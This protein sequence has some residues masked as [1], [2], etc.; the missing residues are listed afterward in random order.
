MSRITL[1]VTLGCIIISRISDR[2]GRRKP[3]LIIAAFTVIPT[4]F[5]LGTMSGNILLVAAFLNGFLLAALPIALEVNVKPK[6]IG[7]PWQVCQ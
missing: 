7:Q 3:F 2:I 1:G 5:A 6:T 4:L